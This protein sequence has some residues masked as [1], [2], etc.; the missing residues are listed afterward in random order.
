[1]I[2]LNASKDCQGVISRHRKTVQGDEMPVLDYIV[3]CDRLKEYFSFMTIDE[4]RHY[5]LTK[6]A[7]TKGVKK[8]SESVH[9][10]L[11]AEFELSCAKKKATVRQ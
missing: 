5:V 4:K 8:K 7:T 9:N 1:M 6:Y 3:V 2:V 10:V 11:Y